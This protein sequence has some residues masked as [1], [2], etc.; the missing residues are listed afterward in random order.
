MKKL[1]LT[2]SC[3]WLLFACDPDGPPADELRAQLVGRWELAHATRGGKATES[4]DGTY[5]VFGEA[6]MESNLSGAASTAPYAL[7]GMRIDSKDPRLTESYKI[8]R[9]SADSLVLQMTMRNLPFEFVLLR[10]PTTD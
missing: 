1:L 7:D 2:G 4:L 10:A 9:L 3:L 8:E 5:F 6:E